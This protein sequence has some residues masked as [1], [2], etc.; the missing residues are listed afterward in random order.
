MTNTLAYTTKVLVTAV[1]SF[2]GQGR[3]PKTNFSL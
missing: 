2:V 3:G 1:K